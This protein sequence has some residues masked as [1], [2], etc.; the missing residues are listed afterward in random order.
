MVYPD[1][2]HRRITMQTIDLNGMT[3]TELD[4]LRSRLNDTLAAKI[5]AEEAAIQERLASLAAIKSGKKAVLPKLEAKYRNPTTGESW[6]G[7]GAQPSW[8]TGE[9]A[10]G[11]KLEDFTVKAA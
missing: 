2:H 7:R 8:L 3:I 11:K 9:L 5:E 10:R 1:L 6:A 4:G